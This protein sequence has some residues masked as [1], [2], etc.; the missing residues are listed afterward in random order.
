M[1]NKNIVKKIKQEKDEQTPLYREMLLLAHFHI[2]I[3]KTATVEVLNIFELLNFYRKKDES[4]TLESSKNMFSFL[5]DL[6]VGFNDDDDV[7]KKIMNIDYFVDNIKN[8]EPTLKEKVVAIKKYY[9]EEYENAKNKYGR[10]S[11]KVGECYGNEALGEMIKALAI[12]S[13]AMI[14]EDEDEIVACKK[15]LQEKVNLYVKENKLNHYFEELEMSAFK[16]RDVINHA[17]NMTERKIHF[18]KKLTFIMKVFFRS[19][20]KEILKTIEALKEKSVDLYNFAIK[21]MLAINISQIDNI[22]KLK[23]EGFR[24]GEILRKMLPTRDEK[25]EVFK[26]SEDKENLKISINLNDIT[27]LNS[28]VVSSDTRLFDEYLE[29]ENCVWDK[30][31]FVNNTSDYNYLG[32]ALETMSKIFAKKCDGLVDIKYEYALKNDEMF[33]NVVFQGLSSL[34]KEKRLVQLF[35]AE[36]YGFNGKDLNFFSSKL[37]RKR[38]GEFLESLEKRATEIFDICFEPLLQ[39][40]LMRKDIVMNPN[41]SESKIKP[42]KF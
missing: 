36:L 20:N 35:C 42:R 34:A 21:K 39:M 7:D 15:N 4:A 32:N 2:S 9:P 14:D 17:M 12:H 33:F 16:E 28:F 40:D 27:N 11:I 37:K 10:C 8:Y 13:Q 30:G 24:P 3:S 25:L 1:F 5:T 23:S 29:D 18:D 6:N 19:E 41:K 38:E 31:V 22:K 26:V